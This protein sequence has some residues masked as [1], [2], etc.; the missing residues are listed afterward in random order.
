MEGL[1]TE[2]ALSRRFRPAPL[3]SCCCSWWSSYGIDISTVLGSLLQL[4]Y[5]FISRLCWAFFRD[6]EPGTWHKTSVSLHGSFN[7][8]TFSSTETA[9]VL[10]ASPDHSWCWAS[11]ALHGFRTS[12]ALETISRY[13]LWLPVW[14]TGSAPSGPQLQCAD[15]KEII[16]RRFC[17][18]NAS[19]FLITA[20]A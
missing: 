11:G 1:A 19:L 18:W 12:A 9:H 2:H 17:L 6:C 5:T 13:H 4:S 20:N 15:A 3:H 10:M 14:G 16:F 8:G 7:L